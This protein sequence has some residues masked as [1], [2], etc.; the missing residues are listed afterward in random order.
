VAAA[1]AR[2]AV[3]E[4]TTAIWRSLTLTAFPSLA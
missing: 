3:V 2:A 4:N 1:L